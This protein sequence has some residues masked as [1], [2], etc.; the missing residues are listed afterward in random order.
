MLSIPSEIMR[1]SMILW[2]F[3]GGKKL[4]NSLNI[5]SKIWRQSL[6][7]SCYWNTSCISNRKFDQIKKLPSHTHPLFYWFVHILMFLIQNI[8]LYLEIYYESKV[9]GET[10]LKRTLDATIA[11]YMIHTSFFA[12]GTLKNLHKS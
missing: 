2:Q 9:R 6:N 3:Q 10:Y 4:I 1:G 12:Q 8:A 11:D 7:R 5:R